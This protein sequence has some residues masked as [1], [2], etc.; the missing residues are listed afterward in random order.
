MMSL[1][2]TRHKMSIRW[3]IGPSVSILYEKKI[4]ILLSLMQ[5]SSPFNE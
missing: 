5:R 1:Y 4:F 2:S 3:L